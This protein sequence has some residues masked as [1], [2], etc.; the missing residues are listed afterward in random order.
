[1]MNVITQ[2]R[3]L[4][5]RKRLAARPAAVIVPRWVETADER[6]PL[7]CVWFALSEPLSD[8]DD[9]PGITR[10]AFSGFFR[11]A[12][13]F[14]FIHILKALSLPLPRIFPLRF[15]DTMQVLAALLLLTLSLSAYAQ[16]MNLSDPHPAHQSKL[17]EEPTPSDPPV[18]MFS[19]P[20]NAPWLITGQANIIFQGHGPFHSPYEGTHS[21]LSR[22]EYKTSLL[23]TLF[24][25]AQVYRNPRYNTDAVVNIESSG[26][27]G[28]SEALGLAGFTNLDVVRNP[29]LGSTPYLARVQIHQTIGL[30]DKLV[31]SERTPFSLA[32]EAPERRLELH[33][34]KM[35]LPDYFDIN[36][37][38]SDSHLQ[39]L[40][41]TIDNNGAWDYAADTRGYT[42]G[43]VLEYHDKDWSARYGIAAMP[44]TANGI[45]LDWAFSRA[46]GQNME[47][48]L[49]KPLLGPLVSADRKGTI[50]ILSF[51]NHANMGLYRDANRAYL[52]GEDPKPDIIAHRKFSSVKYGFG[53]NAEQEVTSDLR[54]FTRFGWNEGQH[55]SF[56]YTEVDQTVNIGGD[57]SGRAW[58]R[59]NDKLGLAF[60]SNA[61]KK[62]HQTYLKLGGLGFLLGDGN[63]N[64]GRENILESYYNLHA[65]RG[66]FYALDLQYITNPGYNRDRGPVLVGAIRMHVDF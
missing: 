17:P 14:H 24:L 52:D 7:A 65:W 51:V 22:G 56:A 34:G 46:S 30:T 25:G 49:R 48:E 32:T 13:Y 6:C 5:Y 44:V 29:N 39:F 31:E 58:S 37:V 40:N 16:E 3:Y 41:W 50:R 26:G 28:I 12:G 10:P 21:L 57:Y 8:Q 45:D 27:R 23:G 63:L 36:S 18:T 59:P 60:V 42:Y 61:I 53:F 2:I 33:L 55:E 64:Y 66:V 15:K 11:K 62:D 35:S 4:S 1:M 9:D 38:G 19:H 54:L 47:F 20:E 43:T